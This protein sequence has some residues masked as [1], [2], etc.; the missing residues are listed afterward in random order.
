MANAHR[1]DEQVKNHEAFRKELEDTYY[2]AEQKKAA[3][4]ATTPA[5]PSDK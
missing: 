5:K 1:T 2:N 4:K 3:K